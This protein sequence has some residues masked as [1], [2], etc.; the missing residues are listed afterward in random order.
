VVTGKALPWIAVLTLAVG[1]FVVEALSQDSRPSADSMAERLRA[2]GIQ[3]TPE[4]I[5]QAR[6]IMDNMRNGVQPDPEQVQKIVSEVRKQ[7][8][9]QLKDALGA[10]DEEWQVLGPK[11]EK[12]QTLTL[13]SRGVGMALGRLGPGGF[14]AGGGTEQTEVQKKLQALQTLLKNKDASPENIRAALKDYRE[15]KAKA[16][17]ELE[18][19]RAELKELVTVRQE[20]LLI[21]MDLLE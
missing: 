5:E 8:Q 14:N 4:Q 7:A 15:A 12:V 16:K 13:Q 17:A 6:Q 1:A 21:T 2:R 9:T 18:K 19:A 10:T 20:A 11:V 3:V